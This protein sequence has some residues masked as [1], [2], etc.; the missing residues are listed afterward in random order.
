M[1][2]TKEQ[3]AQ[4]DLEAKYEIVEVIAR[5]KVALKDEYNLKV[6]WKGWADPRTGRNYTW[7]PEK[8]LL[9]L[10]IVKAYKSGCP[11]DP[12]AMLE[13]S[14]SAHSD[15]DG[16]LDGKPP[17]PTKPK[18]KRGNKRTNKTKDNDNGNVHTGSDGDLNGKP[19][20]KQRKRQAKV[21]EQKKT[22]T[23]V[24]KRLAKIAHP[25]TKAPAQKKGD[26]DHDVIM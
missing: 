12:D 3:Q 18:R 17:T 16:D 4:E 8:N 24:A 26:H 14:D 10:E 22:K 15:S 19:P 20:N 25:G 21:M 6:K 2:R 23:K 1:A 7:E 11:F 13:D 9:N 5:R